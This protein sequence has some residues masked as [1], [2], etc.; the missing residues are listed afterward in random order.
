MSRVKKP[1]VPPY[2]LF[3]SPYLSLSLSIYLSLFLSPF[4]SF[5]LY[6][7]LS[8]YLPHS[9]CLCSPYLISLLSLSFCGSRAQKGAGEK[10]VL[11]PLRTPPHLL[12]H[13]QVSQPLPLTELTCQ[14]MTKTKLCTMWSIFLTYQPR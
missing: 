4:M 1:H 5:C 8:F 3:L 9:F 14:A 7:C 11:A 6:F 10:T 12:P 2:A 13:T